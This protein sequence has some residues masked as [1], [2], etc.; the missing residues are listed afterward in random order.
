MPY[1]A[2]PAAVPPVVYGIR[3]HAALASDVAGLAGAE[4][5]AVAVRVFPDGEIGMRLET[6]AQGRDAVL[7]AGT[8]SEADTL[9]AFD[10][11]HAL[12][13]NGA[14]SLLV[15]LAF[16]GY[17]TKDSF[18]RPGDAVTSRSRAL[19]WSAVPPT[20]GGNRILILEPH[21]RSL[22]FY[23]PPPLRAGAVDA[24]PLVREMLAGS[25]PGD[26]V[27]V[28]GT[29]GADSADW[30]DRA[31][32]GPVACSPD[33]GRIKWVETL[34]SDLG[35][36]TAAVL[37]RRL[38]GSEVES[39]GLCGDVAGRRVVLC[40]DLV[41]SGETLIQAAR[42]CRDSGAAGVSAVAVHG[43]F[44]PGA[45]RKMRDSGLLDGL[46]CTDSHP[47][48]RLEAAAWPGWLR[49][50]PVADLLAGAVASS[51]GMEKAEPIPGRRS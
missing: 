25:E 37:K 33:V 46:V 4:P 19:L 48:A 39:Y 17:S 32:N 44:V 15:L 26:G 11:A 42:L 18:S 28:E 2:E 41:R 14:R 21:S 5:G 9:E 29:A 12:A 1:F 31:G 49:V 16:F 45:L 35:W 51:L 30:T 24:R 40:D 10:L 27:P 6:S 23:F 8:G 47:R 50:D 34:A 36:R 38:S 20:P 22:P 13:A 3:S 7:V 43:A